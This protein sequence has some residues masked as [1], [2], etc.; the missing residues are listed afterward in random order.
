[1][2]AF[3]TAKSELQDSLN[4]IRELHTKWLAQKQNEN[5]KIQIE[6]LI[7]QSIED[8]EHLQE[9]LD[10][11][12]KNAVKFN[13]ATKDI[14]S[15]KQFI[16]AS[17]KTIETIRS[18]INNPTYASKNNNVKG[19]KWSRLN[20]EIERENDQFIGS[21]IQKNQQLRQQTEIELDEFAK[22]AEALHQ[23]SKDLQTELIDQDEVL[24]NVKQ[25]VEVTEGR[26]TLAIKKVNEL[27]DKTNE[28]TSWCIIIT[29]IVVLAGLVVAVVFV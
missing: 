22:S 27:L 28:K 14:L 6:E 4:Q 17:T 21:Q 9:A 7:N 12:D 24:E 19:D 25:D 11:I 29:L 20:E 16:S 5:L 13:V 1:M 10:I 3:E 8:L 18:N 15:N 23:L 2:E 26:M